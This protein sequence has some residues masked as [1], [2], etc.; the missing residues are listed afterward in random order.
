M[1][2]DFIPSNQCPWRGIIIR[3]IYMFTL[4]DIVCPLVPDTL[5]VTDIQ[6]F[7]EWLSTD[8][9]DYPGFSIHNGLKLF[10]WIINDYYRLFE[11]PK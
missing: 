6:Q 7:Q 1:G 9:G 3:V 2:H 10:L 4:L 5:D 8:P 11:E